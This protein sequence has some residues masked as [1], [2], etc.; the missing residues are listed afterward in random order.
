[1]ALKGKKDHKYLLTWQTV[2]VNYFFFFLF[3]LL[4]CNYFS[5]KV[6]KL[7][8]VNLVLQF[9]LRLH[10]TAIFDSLFCLYEWFLILGK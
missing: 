9:P 7:T 1:M 5:L 3:L 8:V 2:A 10:L 6:S 4:N